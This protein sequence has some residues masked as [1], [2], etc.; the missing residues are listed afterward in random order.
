LIE[1][2]IILPKLLKEGTF[3]F[4]LLFMKKENDWKDRLGVVFSTKPDFE[5][6]Q[7]SDVQNETLPPE[8]QDL[9]VQLST[10]HRK[11][12]TVTLVTGYTG[13]EEDLRILE[14]E[15][16]TRCATGGSSKDMEIILQGDCRGKIIAYLK[17][18]NYRV[19]G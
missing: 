10:K 1:T 14:K 7:D 13:K 11:G 3:A 4:L 16:K 9:R 2:L 18:R 17:S 8:K 19:K 15:L 6:K 5:Y 12:K